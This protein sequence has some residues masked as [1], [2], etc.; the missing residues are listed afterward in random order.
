M[1]SSYIESHIPF[2]I[3]ARVLLRREHCSN[4]FAGNVYTL[5]QY[6]KR[7]AELNVGKKLINHIGIGQY[8]FPKNLYVY[9]HLVK[10]M[11]QQQQKK[12]LIR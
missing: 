11:A 8:D 10:I 12:C 6:D 9:E 1:R 3:C 7:K 2:N 4:S 5:L